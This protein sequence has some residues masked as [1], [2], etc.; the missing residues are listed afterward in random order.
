MKSLSALLVKFGRGYAA[1]STCEVDD[2]INWLENHGYNFQYLDTYSRNREPV[3]EKRPLPEFCADTHHTI[4][5]FLILDVND[6]LGIWDHHVHDIKNHTVFDTFATR[7][8]TTRVEKRIQNLREGGLDPSFDELRALWRLAG[9]Q[10][11]GP[12]IETATMPEQA[13]FDFLRLLLKEK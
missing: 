1:I 11:H 6:D 8:R 7:V 9:G 5:S 12:R 13:L 3:L 2:W 10:F 4:L